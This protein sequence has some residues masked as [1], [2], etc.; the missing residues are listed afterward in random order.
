MYVC[1]DLFNEKHQRYRVAE[2]QLCLF[3]LRQL[4][5]C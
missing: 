3:S 2:D 1:V 5:G 4:F